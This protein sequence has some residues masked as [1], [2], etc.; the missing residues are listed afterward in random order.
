MP[1]ITKD[2]QLESWSMGKSLT[3]TLFALL[4]KDG[5]FRV[6]RSA[7][8]PDWQKPGDPRAA[9]RIADLL[10]MSSGLKFIADR[11]PITRPTRATPIHTLIYTVRSTR[12]STR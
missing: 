7:P 11:I 4:V 6:K 2:T 10:H 5:V 9:I 12:S 1:G 3:A 8:V